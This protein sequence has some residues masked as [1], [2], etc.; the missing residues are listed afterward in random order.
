MIRNIARPEQCLIGSIIRKP[1]LYDEISTIIQ[2]N[3]FDDTFHRELFD[4]ISRQ[5]E[6]DKSV[7]L[8]G[9]SEVYE[10]NTGKDRFFEIARLASE[11]HGEYNIKHYAGL[12]NQY[13]IEKKLIESATQIIELVNTEGDLS[14]TIQ[15]SQQLILDVTEKRNQQEVK[16]VKDLVRSHVDI[17]EERLSREGIL[18]GMSSGY[19]KLDE[20][21]GGLH[22]G[23]LIIIA[24]RPSMGKTTLAMN[25]AEN[26][27]ENGAVLTFSLEMT[28][29]QLMDRSLSSLGR[30]NF[31]RIRTGKLED[32]EWPKLT[33]ASTRLAGFN[34]Y[35]DDTPGISVND[36]RSTARRVSRKSKLKLIVVDYLQLMA[37]KGENRTQQITEI[38]AGLKALAKENEC[39]VI[40]LSQLNR[41]VETR[42]DKRPMMSDLRESGAIEQDA[43]VIAFVYRDEYYNKDTEHKGIAEINFAKQRNGP[44]G[45]EYM[46]FRGDLCRFDTLDGE[47]I[48]L[49]VDNHQPGGFEYKNKFGD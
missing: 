34:L 4:I 18:S 7:N 46:S 39:P 47:V 32:Y 26:A 29:E 14:K 25:I 11:T 10:Q 37:G 2:A 43:D 5:I 31:S 3:D 42:K 36:A 19:E 12:I 16:H 20:R 8:I 28:A 33:I 45:V 41:S 6:N 44:V 23:D 48:P 35:I 27:A 49:E 21:T 13:S 40:A 30:I 15:E 17:L 1:D 22:P 24:G 9:V 38:S